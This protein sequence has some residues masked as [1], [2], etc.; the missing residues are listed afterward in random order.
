MANSI[1]DFDG[2]VFAPGGD[3]PIYGDIKDNTGLANGTKVNTTMFTDVF[4][5]FARLMHDSGVAFNHAKD[6]Y[7]SSQFKD[8]LD[9][10][11]ASVIAAAWGAWASLSANTGA[12][13]QPFAI[14]DPVRYSKDVLGR[15]TFQKKLRPDS[16]VTSGSNPFTAAMP[17]GYRPSYD[18]AIPVVY[19]QG[20]TGLITVMMATINGTSGVIEIDF[21]GITTDNDTTSFVDFSIVNYNTN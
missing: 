10:N 20:S 2:Q 9:A 17:S 13:W 11:T 21:S 5:F 16:S 12:G 7:V 15:V 4:Q 19:Y 6:T 1:Q 14:P 8:A 3:N 18:V